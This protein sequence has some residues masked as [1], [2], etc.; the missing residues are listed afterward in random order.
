MIEQPFEKEQLSRASSGDKD[1]LGKL[2]ETYGTQLH[3]YCRH[4]VRRYSHADICVEDIVQEVW[5]KV[6]SHIS[7]YDP[8]RGDFRRWLFTVAHRTVIDVMR[9]NARHKKIALESSEKCLNKPA[10]SDLERVIDQELKQALELFTNNAKERASFQSES[11]LV[12]RACI[13][14]FAPEDEVV[15]ELVNLY[16]ALNAYHIACGGSG[17]VIDDWQSFVRELQEAGVF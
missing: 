12:L 8:N 1:A 16:R 3:A 15:E 13:S 14:E 4:L 6:F 7:K 11:R 17:L 9:M 2:Y 10:S 5:I